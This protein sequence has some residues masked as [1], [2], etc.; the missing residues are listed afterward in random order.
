MSARLLVGDQVIVI[1]GKDKGKRGA[2][3]KL[4]DDGERVVVSGLNMISRHTR[5]TQARPEGGIIRREAAMA[6]C[7]VMPIDP[8]TG[9]GTRVRFSGANTESGTAK[10]RVAVSGADL[11][12]VE[13]RVRE[14]QE[15]RV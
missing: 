5:P 14:S 1:S 3:V 7:K 13:K 11:P 10:K 2:V 9:K 4:V 8:S 6:S 12:A 15:S